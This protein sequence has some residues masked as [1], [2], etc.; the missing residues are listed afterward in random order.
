VGPAK[1]PAGRTWPKGLSGPFINRTPTLP[2]RSQG[3]R[4]ARTIGGEVSELVAAPRERVGCD[5][6]AIVEVD[7][8]GNGVFN[9]CG[10]PRSFMKHR[11]RAVRASELWDYLGDRRDWAAK[12]TDSAGLSGSSST[13]RQRTSG[14]GRV[15]IGGQRD[16]ALAIKGHALS[17]SVGDP[18][19]YLSNTKGIRCAVSLE[20]AA[21]LW[22][23]SETEPKTSGDFVVSWG[24][25]RAD[26]QRASI[27]GEG[28]GLPTGLQ[29]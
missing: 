18:V 13:G 8:H 4:P 24:D 22:T 14:W 25:F 10:P 2:D 9:H 15:Q 17:A 16:S 5:D 29:T 28:I 11:L 21:R 27:L 23:R 7:A 19:L 12:S 6:I 20:V 1:L 3:F 26:C